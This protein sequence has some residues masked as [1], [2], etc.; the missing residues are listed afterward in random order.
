MGMGGREYLVIRVIVFHTDLRT[1]RILRGGVE[2]RE[3]DG[4][5]LIRE[6]SEYDYF[7]GS[8]RLDSEIWENGTKS[9]RFFSEWTDKN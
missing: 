7:G 9:K 1:P 4:I 2:G 5:V 6:I 8:A 3:G